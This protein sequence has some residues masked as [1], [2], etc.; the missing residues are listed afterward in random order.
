ML[1]IQKPGA[2]KYLGRGVMQAKSLVG[3]EDLAAALSKILGKEDDRQSAYPYYDYAEGSTN[4]LQA[5]YKQFGDS[6]RPV[7]TVDPF[8]TFE[9]EFRF[10]PNIVSYTNVTKETKVDLGGSY[11][12]TSRSDS[13]STKES[14]VGKLL[15]D[16]Q[17]SNMT[18]KDGGTSSSP[19]MNSSSS[20]TNEWDQWETTT[21]TEQSK[22]NLHQDLIVNLGIYIQKF[23]LPNVLVDGG[24]DVT[25][26]VGKFPV[27]GNLVQPSDNS[28]SL[29]MVNTESPVI[30]NVFYP[31]MRETTLPWWSYDSQPFTT[32]TVTLDF[33]EHA[34]VKYHF[35]GC[36]PT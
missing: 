15:G 23:S 36:R 16:M 32:A 9:C 4:G 12:D 21:H 10:Y 14:V 17:F 1:G 5:F 3:G 34:D 11:E 2:G 25:T 7:E 13:V 29:E 6:S 8:Q 27:P 18:Q 19:F 20:E 26:L 30:E 33:T 28:F 22:T 35:F 31:W 24:E